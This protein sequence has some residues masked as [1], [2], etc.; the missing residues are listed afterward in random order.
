MYRFFFLKRIEF[1][2][3]WHHSRDKYLSLTFKILYSK[4]S[5][6]RKTN[7]NAGGTGG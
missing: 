7:Q 4:F 1:N 6:I 2:D 5:S 3:T